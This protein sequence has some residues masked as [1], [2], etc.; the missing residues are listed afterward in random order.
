[1]CKGVLWKCV[2]YLLLQHLHIKRIRDPMKQNIAMCHFFIHEHVLYGKIFAS[3]RQ[4]L[5][6][7]RERQNISYIGKRDFFREASLTINVSD[8][9]L[10]LHAMK[11]SHN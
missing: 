7:K 10:F 5:N 3:G 2:K 4:C 1:M 8:V 11:I 6:S 9:T